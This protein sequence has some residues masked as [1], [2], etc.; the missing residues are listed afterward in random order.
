[1]CT[2]IFPS[3]TDLAAEQC[4]TIMAAVMVIVSMSRLLLTFQ[5]H[6][7]AFTVSFFRNNYS[8]NIMGQDQ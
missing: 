4:I 1:M 3:V 8:G 7:M 2:V 6:Q 5:N